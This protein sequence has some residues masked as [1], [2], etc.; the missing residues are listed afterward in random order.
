M[1]AAEQG[2]CVPAG[3]LQ[4]GDDFG[5]EFALTADWQQ[6]TISFS[7][8]TQQSWGVAA[9]FDPSQA[10][11]FAFQHGDTSSG[12][13]FWIDEIE[14]TGGQS[15]MT[16]PE[17][18]EPPEPEVDPNVGKP[19]MCQDLGGYQG[20]GSVTFY[21]FSMGSSEVN[22]SYPISGETVPGI[23]TGGGRFGAMNTSDYNN[24]AMC[25]A[26]VEVT[27]DGNRSVTITIVDQCPVATNPK[28]TAGHIDLSREA[29]NQ[30]GSEGEGHIGTGNGG[31]VGSIS[32]R[33]VECPVTGDVTFR[34]KEPSN[35]NWNQVLVQGH[36]YPL[37][38]VEVNVGGNWVAAARQD[39]N[40]WEP[41]NGNMGTPP[42]QVRATD[43]TGSYLVAEVPLADGAHVGTPNQ[44]PACQ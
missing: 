39:Y 13:D 17:N 2:D 24:S 1:G 41:P 21:T 16:D 34:L 33:Y 19:G 23:P 4:C 10:L 7:D 3:D 8:L 11:G 40:Y 15:M 12:F 38:S 32:W 31:A 30:I 14:L 27:R 22:C 9:T 44:F 37:A 35:A 20:N 42:F 26:C 28:C 18:M 36:R 6:H 43:V 25:G 29:F 5:A